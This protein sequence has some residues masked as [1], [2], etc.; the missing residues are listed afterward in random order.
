MCSLD[1]IICDFHYKITKGAWSLMRLKSFILTDLAVPFLTSLHE[2]WFSQNDLLCVPDFLLPH[3]CLKLKLIPLPPS[4][5]HLPFY[6]SHSSIRARSRGALWGHHSSTTRLCDLFFLNYCSTCESASFNTCLQP[7]SITYLFMLKWSP[8]TA[9]KLLS[10]G[11][12][13]LVFF[14]SHAES[15]NPLCVGSSFSWAV[16]FSLVFFPSPNMNSSLSF[17]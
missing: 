5:F 1:Y 2:P 17:C 4:S 16:L 15:K 6:K 9:C 11:Q 3:V 13:D 10:D 7:G 12:L 14:W 8:Q